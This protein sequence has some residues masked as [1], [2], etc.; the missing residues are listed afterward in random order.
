MELWENI[1]DGER[2]LRVRMYVALSHRLCTSR[3]GSALDLSLL[4]ELH[5]N[6]QI[7]VFSDLGLL[8]FFFLSS[9]FNGNVKAVKAFR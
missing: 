7:T 2:G 8:P 9:Y 5:T 1:R 3:H 4:I 6:F